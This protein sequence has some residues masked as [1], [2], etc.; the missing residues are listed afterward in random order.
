MGGAKPRD[1][2]REAACRH[3]PLCNL[4]CTSFAS[5]RPS[6]PQGAG[7]LPRR[8]ARRCASR[9]A[10]FARCSQRPARAKAI[11]PNT[12]S[13]LAASRSAGGVC[14]GRPPEGAQG[15]H[16][17]RLWVA[18]HRRASSS[19]LAGQAQSSSA[20]SP[21]RSPRAV[22]APF[23]TARRVGSGERRASGELASCVAR[24]PSSHSG[25]RRGPGSELPQP[26]SCQ[27][28]SV[29]LLPGPAAAAAPRAGG[30]CGAWLAAAPRPWPSSPKA[31]KPP[32]TAP[33]QCQRRRAAGACSGPPRC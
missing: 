22:V 21:K 20:K 19:E 15:T 27:P 4:R 3:S 33:T 32:N 2:R 26:P 14:F 25:K 30:G 10:E 23:G 28:P 7:L 31:A 11:L 24:S 13:R 9:W 6:S 5:A 12:K 16:R 1:W 18:A 29:Q 8:A 17:E